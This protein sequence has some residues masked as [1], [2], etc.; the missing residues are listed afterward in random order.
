MMRTALI[1]AAALAMQ[2]HSIP[3]P[4]PPEYHPLPGPYVVRIDDD[5]TPTDFS[6]L[7]NAINRWTGPKYSAFLLCFQPGR[8]PSF[9]DAAFKSISAVSRGLKA[10]GAAMVVV[11]PERRCRTAPYDNLAD[12]AYLEILGVLREQD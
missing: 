7:D 2:T 11:S 9:P 4:P 8:G 10:R 5:G 1:S 6:V 12:V 3:P